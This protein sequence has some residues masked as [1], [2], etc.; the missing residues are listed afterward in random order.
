MIMEN[1]FSFVSTSTNNGIPRIG[2]WKLHGRP[3]R[4]N[5]CSS[6]EQHNSGRTNVRKTA[7]TSQPI[8]PT[9][10]QTSSPTLSTIAQSADGSLVPI[11]EK[12]QIV[13]F[14][15]FSLQNVLH[16]PKLSYLSDL[17]S[18]RTIG[19]ARHS[20]GLYILNDD[21]SAAHLIN[22]M[23]SRILHLQTPLECLKES[24]PSTRLVL[25]VP[26]RV[27][28]CTA[29][30]H[31][32]GP[33]QTKFTPRAQACVFVEYLPHQREGISERKTSPLPVSRRLQ[34]KT[35]N[36]LEIKKKR[37]VVM[38]LKS[39]QKPV[40][41]KLNRHKA[42]LVAKGFTQTYGVDYS[43]TFSP[44]AKLNTVRVLLSVVVHKG[45]P[46]YQLD[47]KNAFLNGDLV[48]E[49]YMSPPPNFEA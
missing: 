49:V 47:V 8:G 17:N 36:L 43:E 46:L 38:R 9:A 32:F 11:A 41:M 6:N 19:T 24:Y 1:Q 20:M 37:T 22:R 21:T 33:N 3:P 34:S 42:R 27:F 39:E 14:D 16:V 28:G 35:P 48:E 4:G 7:S 13:L 29:Y 12:V 26:L 5:K 10:S 31:S 30:V 40:T 18:G 45:Q 15:G 2:V 44:I 23:P 25:K